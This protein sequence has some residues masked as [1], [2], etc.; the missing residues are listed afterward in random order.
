MPK[1]SIL[2]SIGFLRNYDF[3]DSSTSSHTLRMYGDG[4]VTTRIQ[5]HFVSRLQRGLSRQTRPGNRPRKP[6][7]FRLMESLFRLESYLQLN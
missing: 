3:P 2:W 7:W 4:H 1:I 6:L 5:R